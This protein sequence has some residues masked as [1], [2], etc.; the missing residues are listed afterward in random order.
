MADAE[1]T[2]AEQAGERAAFNTIARAAGE[3]LGKLASLFVFA[4]LGRKLGEQGVGVYFFGLSYGAI[5]L[6]PIDLG[7][8]RSLLREAA[9]ARERA[10]ALMRTVVRW[11]LLI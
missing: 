6:I 2:A 10:R 1:L 3:V 7:F 4:F 9:P 11:K 8:D 5:V